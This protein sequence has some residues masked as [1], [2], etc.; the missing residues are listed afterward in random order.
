MVSGTHYTIS[1]VW[2]FKNDKFAVLL[3]G[4]ML[5]NGIMHL[6]MEDLYYYY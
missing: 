1:N 6:K 5:P 4:I 3:L 2:L